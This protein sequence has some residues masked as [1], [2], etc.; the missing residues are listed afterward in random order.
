M[1]ATEAAGFVFTL[2]RSLFDLTVC[3]CVVTSDGRDSSAEQGSVPQFIY[4]VTRCRIYT[5][6]EIQVGEA[7]SHS[8]STSHY[9]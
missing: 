4:T 3:R 8:L 7:L 6:V 9:N 5:V 1:I 2:F